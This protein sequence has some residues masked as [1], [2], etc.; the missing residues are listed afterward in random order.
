M[1][2]KRYV[3]SIIKHFIYLRIIIFFYSFSGGVGYII[4][5]ILVLEQIIISEKMKFNGI[6]YHSDVMTF[7][8]HKIF[9]KVQICNV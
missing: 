6:I 3:G 2:Y 9:L 5:Y 1:G 4:Q 8:S 7:N